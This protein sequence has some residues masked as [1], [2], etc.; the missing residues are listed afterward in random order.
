MKWFPQCVTIGMSIFL[1]I[2]TSSQLALASELVVPT[3]PG[4]VSGEGTEFSVTDSGYLD[5]TLYADVDVFVSIQSMPRM[6][7]L[8]LEAIEDTT[9]SFELFGLKPSTTYHQYTDG[10]ESH[11][12]FTSNSDGQFS[13]SLDLSEPHFLIIQE[14]ESTLFLRNDELGGDCPEFGAWN[15]DTLTCTMTRD[16]SETIQFSGIGITLDGN[17]HSNIGPGSGNGVFVNTVENNTIKNLFVSNYSRGVFLRSR[18]GHVV[19]NTNI[20]NVTFG[21]SVSNGNPITLRDNNISNATAGIDMLGSNLTVTGNVVSN[22]SGSHALGVIQSNNV[23]LTDNILRAS[24][25][26]LAIRQTTNATV[27]GNEL[28]EGGFL[29]FGETDAQH[30]HDIQGTNKIQGK[31]IIFITHETGQTYDNFLSAGYIACAFCEE[32]TFRN[33]ALQ[34]GHTGM[35]LYKTNNSLIASSSFSGNTYGIHLNNSGNNT[36]QTNEFNDNT[37]HVF[38]QGSDNALIQN[39]F[40][41]SLSSP[42]VTPASNTL[43]TILSRS[44]PVGGN[45]WQQFDESGEGCSDVNG[46]TVCD[47]AFALEQGAG[48]FVTDEFP[49]ISNRAWENYVPLVPI[50]SATV[51]PNLIEEGGTTTLTWASNYADT[52]FFNEGIGS[53]TLSGEAVFTLFEDTTFIGTFSGPRGTTTCSATVEVESDEP[54]PQTLGEKA[55]ALA[56]QLIDQPDAYELGARGWDYENE[57]F[58]SPEEIYTGYRYRNGLTKQVVF[59]P[60]IDCSGLIYWAFN[61]SNDPFDAYTNYVADLTA[62]GM[63]G[64][65]QSDPVLEGDLGSGDTLSF[66]WG[67]YD[68]ITN[69][70]DGVKDGHIDHVAMYVS[71]NEEYDVVNAGSEATGIVGIL[72]STVANLPGFVN[73]RRIHDYTGNAYVMSGSP[74]DLVITDPEGNTLSYDQVTSSDEEFIREVPGELYYSEVQQGHDGK[75][76]DVVYISTLKEGNYSVQVVPNLDALPTD[77]YT[78]TFTSASTTLVL[79]E[80]ETI[81]SIPQTGFTVQVSEDSIEVVE[82]QTPEGLFNDLLETAKQASTSPYFLKLRIIANIKTAEYFYKKSKTIYSKLVLINLKNLIERRTGSGIYEQDAQAMTELIEQLLVLLES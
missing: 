35:Y 31:P 30:E 20:A 39:N 53:T 1:L 66:D 75:P 37:H 71:G 5:V 65:Q 76:I 38:V 57:V 9:I 46:D 11:S 82:E 63:F 13:F 50:C 60:G 52:A 54:E 29:F 81:E 41:E 7:E 64:N 18:G 23:E 70:W 55:A 77:T 25:T 24:E 59:G 36:I 14:N 47:E 79:V 45:H 4:F 49:W 67:K 34:P 56:R 62:H 58:V 68:P 42:I 61:K 22:V 26:A 27:S 69:T 40:L 51:A 28:E 44:L 17:G 74:V 10:Y 72:R 43:G 3:I 16:V 73:Y 32:V 8:S 2:P 33:F 48:T 21:I 12:T 6:I 19:E 15:P 78:L 80:N